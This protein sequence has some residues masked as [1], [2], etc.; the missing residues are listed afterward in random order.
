[1]APNP[2]A[3]LPKTNSLPYQGLSEPREN[4][5]NFLPTQT[6]YYNLPES[7][8]LAR[9]PPKTSHQAR[10]RKFP[11]HDR[12]QTFTCPWKGRPQPNFSTTV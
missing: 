3:H 2:S 6:L 10:R 4:P 1:M 5:K 11:Q 7:V 9:E 8:E 12:N